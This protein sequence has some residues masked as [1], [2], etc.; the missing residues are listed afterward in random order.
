M[1]K[2]AGSTNSTVIETKGI[3]V[4]A[5]VEASFELK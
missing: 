1:L 5:S 2:A 4:N 3:K